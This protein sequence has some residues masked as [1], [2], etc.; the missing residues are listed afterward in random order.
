MYTFHLEAAAD[1]AA[2]QPDSAHP[3]VTEL[4]RAVRA[5]GMHVGVALKPQTP[6]ELVVPYVEAGLVDMVLVL[7][8]NPGFGGQRFMGGDVIGKC[9]ALRR[10]FPALHIQVDGG[11]APSTI[12]EVA[13]AGANVIVAGSAVFGAERPGEVMAALRGSVDRAAGG[14]AEAAAK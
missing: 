2:L 14:G 8:V 10:R 5:A 11:V 6:V 1:V 9:A 13:A 3:S 12:D 7:T 4:A